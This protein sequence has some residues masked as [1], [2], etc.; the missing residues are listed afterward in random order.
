MTVAVRRRRRFARILGWAA[1]LVIVLIL[2]TADQDPLTWMLT[3]AAFAGGYWG[4]PRLDRSRQRRR[5]QGP[6]S[7][8]TSGRA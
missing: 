6:P 4:R 1:G 3:A 5:G 2:F 7:A 8:R